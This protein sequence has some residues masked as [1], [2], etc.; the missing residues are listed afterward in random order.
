MTNDLILDLRQ[1][2]DKQV[3][4]V[5]VYGDKAHYERLG[6]ADEGLERIEIVFTDGTRIVASYWTTEMGGLCV[7]EGED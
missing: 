1:H 4:A 2:I 3:A 5:H 6:Y 7:D